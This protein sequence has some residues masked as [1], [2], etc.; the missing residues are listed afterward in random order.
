MP[1]PAN[2]PYTLPTDAPYQLIRSVAAILPPPPDP[3]PDAEARRD[4]AIIARVAAL[5]PNDSAESDLASSRA[6]SREA[7]GQSA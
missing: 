2:L 3:S 1:A 7:E 5:Q 4:N 6:G